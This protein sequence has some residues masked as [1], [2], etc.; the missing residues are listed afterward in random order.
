MVKQL[1][2]PNGRTLLWRPAVGSGR[3]VLLRMFGDAVEQ[4]AEPPLHVRRTASNIAHQF[5]RFPFCAKLLEPVGIVVDPHEEP[6]NWNIEN[7]RNVP[8]SAGGYA[9][10]AAFIFLQLLEGQSELVGKGRLAQAA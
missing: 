6:R 5:E 2:C 3:L 10:C 1:L 7:L 9:I 4:R 8:Q